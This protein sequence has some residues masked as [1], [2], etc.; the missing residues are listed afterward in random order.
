MTMTDRQKI[1][2]LLLACH[3]YH[4]ALDMSFTMLI[5]MS[6]RDQRA[7]PPEPFFPSKSPMWPKMVEAKALVD[8]VKAKS[9]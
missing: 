6:R 3:E 9:E 2:A 1:A 8:L 4:D 7:V 5:Q